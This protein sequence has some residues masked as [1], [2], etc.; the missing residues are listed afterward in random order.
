[1]I[2]ILPEVAQFLHNQNVG[3]F[4]PTTATGNIFIETKPDKPDIAICLFTTAG[5]PDAELFPEDALGFQ[6]I[7]RGNFDASI[8]FSLAAAVYDKLHGFRKGKLITTG[9]YIISI[10]GLQTPVSIGK[11]EKKRQEYSIN[12]IAR[13]S[14]NNTNRGY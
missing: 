8:A 12:F 2:S 10:M 3:I 5:L 13:V 11:D 14:G 4:T 7:I 9:T 6:V 1:M